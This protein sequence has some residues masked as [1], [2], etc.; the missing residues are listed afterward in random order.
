MKERKYSKTYPITLAY[1][2]GVLFYSFN[3]MENQLHYTCTTDY[4][5]E[6]R[7]ERRERERDGLL[8]SARPQSSESRGGRFEGSPVAGSNSAPPTFP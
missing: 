4:T 7:K 3:T 8:V 6:V 1:I 5:F 2:L